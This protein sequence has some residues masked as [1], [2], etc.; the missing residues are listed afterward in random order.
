MC[1][2]VRVFEGGS[3]VWACEIEICL[4]DWCMRYGYNKHF[5]SYETIVKCHSKYGA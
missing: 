5:L 2:C 4:S 1:T 3:C